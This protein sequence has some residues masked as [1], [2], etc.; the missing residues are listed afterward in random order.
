MGCTAMMHTILAERNECAPAGAKIFH[1]RASGVIGE[2]RIDQD[3][4]RGMQ[5]LSAR[6]RFGRRNTLVAI[7]KPESYR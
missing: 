5:F 2:I 6:R 7:A 3:L 4:F 1:R